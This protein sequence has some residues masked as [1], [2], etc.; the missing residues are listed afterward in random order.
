MPKVSKIERDKR[1]HPQ[2]PQFLI[3]VLK[4]NGTRA[5]ANTK[6]STV[7]DTYLADD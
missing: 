1:F 2:Y 4:A 7:R 3:D 6:L 5:T